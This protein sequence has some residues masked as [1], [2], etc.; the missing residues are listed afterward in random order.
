[1]RT[2][3]LLAGATLIIVLGVYYDFDRKETPINKQMT[4]KSSL[5]TIDDEPKSANKEFVMPMENDKSENKIQS[6]V[7]TKTIINQK[8]Q[9]S[10]LN[11][12]ET[13]K[14]KKKILAASKEQQININSKVTKLEQ[15]LHN[16]A[17]RADLV[18]ELKNA[19][20]YREVILEKAKRE[21]N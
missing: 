10:K 19:S 8:K 5:L 16:K 11:E 6:N 13:K 3:L 9:Q 20:S 17:T 4:K 18:E 21:I 15:D 14:H 1:M 2:L 12:E 7:S